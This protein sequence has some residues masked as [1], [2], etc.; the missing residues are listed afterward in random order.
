MDSSQPQPTT[1]DDYIA[2]Y[3]E[4]IQARLRAMRETIRAAAPAAQEKISYGMPTFV[5][6]GALVYFGVS[7]NHIGFYP[8]PNGIEAF[9]EELAPYKSGKGSAQFP[10]DQPLPLDLVTK[11]TQYRMAENAAKAAKKRKKD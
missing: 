7:K 8:T 4:D 5:Y 9:Q 2:A 3:P 1:I 10:H 11:I 6:N